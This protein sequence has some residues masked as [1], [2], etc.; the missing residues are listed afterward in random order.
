MSEFLFSLAFSGN[1][2][3]PTP[4]GNPEKIQAIIAQLKEILHICQVA[5]NLSSS[6]APDAASLGYVGKG[7]MI[8]LERNGVFARKTNCAS[9]NISHL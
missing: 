9:S 5:T 8:S 4:A 6:Q 3:N 2:A 7:G 1:E